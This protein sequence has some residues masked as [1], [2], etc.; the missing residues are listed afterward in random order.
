MADP[1]E[2]WSLERFVERLD[3]WVEV[4]QPPEPVRVAV[5]RAIFTRMEDPYQG[6]RRVEGHDNYWF[7]VIPRSTHEGFVVTWSY[8]I[9]EAAR[10]VRCDMISTLSAPA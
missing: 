6:V 3:Q 4:E 9:F 7:G 10:T 5:T 1:G 8:R 2:S